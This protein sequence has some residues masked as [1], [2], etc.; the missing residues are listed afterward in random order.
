MEPIYR[1]TY[2]IRDCDIDC[3][4]RLRPSM[5]LFYAQDIA[6]QH[7]QLMSLGYEALAER[8]LFWAVV[9]HRVQVT[10]L[11]VEGETITVETWPMPTT[12]SAYPRSTVAYDAD[13]NE[14][15]RSI[16]LWILMDANTRDMVVPGKSGVNV[17]GLLRGSELA[18]PH[19]LIPGHLGNTRV[20]QVSFTDL[21]Q[22]GHMNNCR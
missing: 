20:R 3:Y 1:Q 4:G 7:C 15:F 14:L 18:V 12:R 21:D 6:G 17:Q 10:R 8:G 5:I 16:A 11:P 22:N 2:Q 19:S 9:R 13:G